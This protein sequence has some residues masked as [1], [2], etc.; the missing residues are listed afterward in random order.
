M[1]QFAGDEV[2]EDRL[3]GAEFAYVLRFHGYP[4]VSPAFVPNSDPR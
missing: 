2:P 3:V 4:D 1:L